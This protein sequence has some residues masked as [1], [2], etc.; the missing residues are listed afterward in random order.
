MT[1]LQSPRPAFALDLHHSN[2]RSSFTTPDRLIS[3]PHSPLIT[4]TDN[5]N[6][7]K[8]P[9]SRASTT[10][11]KTPTSANKPPN[12]SSNAD[13]GK[14]SASK[15]SHVICKFYKAGNCSAGSACQFSHSLPEVGQGK[16]ICQW[17]VKG[18]CR[19]AHKC[20]LAHILPGQPMSMDR[21]N[22]R[23][24]QAAAR[25][26]AAP[27]SAAAPNA[28]HP[29]SASPSELT[30]QIAQQGFHPQS[31]DVNDYRQH[32]VV[33]SNH[34][35]LK[36][37]SNHLMNDSDAEHPSAHLNDELEF[38]LPDDFTTHPYHHHHL[39]SHPIGYQIPSQQSHPANQ[40]SVALSSPVRTHLN[41]D[42]VFNTEHHP[43]S[44]N[45]RP[46]S[47]EHIRV[48]ISIS[49]GGVNG[50]WARDQSPSPFG[51]GSPFSAPGS[52]S[53]FLPRPGSF[54]SE[55]GF[56]RS[57]PSAGTSPRLSAFMSN[58]SQLDDGL[59]WNH[60]DGDED[61]TELLPSSLHSL[62]TPEERHR[63]HL[64]KHTHQLFSQSVPTENLLESFH[65]P[66]SGLHSP[67]PTLAVRTRSPPPPSHL[68]ESSASTIRAPG[69]LSAS[70]IPASTHLPSWPTAAQHHHTLSPPL[71]SSPAADHAFLSHAPGTSLP[72]GL[73]AGLSRLHF[74]PP[75][76]TGLTPAC[77]P[78]NG[79]GLFNDFSK[80]SPVESTHLGPHSAL[81]QR[82]AG[83]AGHGA[84]SLMAIQGSPL[85]RNV[86]YG[87][88]AAFEPDE[89]DE[90]HH[91]NH[92][93]GGLRWRAS[94]E[95]DDAPFELEI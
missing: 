65:K 67:L 6:S 88:P 24:A 35:Q 22:K 41:S 85:S 60:A 64:R 61:V 62:L 47:P 11:P 90:T 70:Y 77:S 34:P 86:S 66:S 55:D 27:T 75:L 8:E 71:L 37:R 2:S 52:R 43:Q 72:Q 40:F 57:A 12:T 94:A 49:R 9:T 3:Q 87:F 33:H 69:P 56:P 16:P 74:Q 48:P 81:S 18:N 93:S 26:A 89:D 59:L 28:S 44:R 78:S 73:A 38:G 25:E 20:A 39:R 5:I 36:S 1:A 82:L 7:P 80:P 13:S 50:G 21:K 10:T 63:Q 15:V 46:V 29:L 79:G 23:A 58:P 95:D 92:P 19:F 54:G 4:R 45:S 32:E 30:F 76:H 17:F 14:K 51:A 42:N 31:N 84:R 53:V 83:A 91:S 68:R